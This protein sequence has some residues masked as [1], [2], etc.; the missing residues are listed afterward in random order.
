[1]SYI[2]TPTTPAHR[3]QSLICYLVRKG[4]EALPLL[5][6]WG[7]ARVRDKSNGT[8]IIY[9]NAKGR[10]KWPTALRGLYQDWMSEQ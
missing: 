2:K 9:K 10:E 3:L 1:M 6:E 4:F 8:F 7:I 5:S